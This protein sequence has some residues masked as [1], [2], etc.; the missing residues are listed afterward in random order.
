MKPSAPTM[1]A[2]RRPSPGERFRKE[3]EAAELAGGDRDR[4]TLRLTLGDA[5]LLKR[6]RTL[7]VTD[8]SYADG[9]M[10][11]L[12]VRVEPGGVATSALVADA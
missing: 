9:A 4:M 7:A 1:A 12:G 11:F 2:G 3:I 6:D 5:S 8:I 10:R